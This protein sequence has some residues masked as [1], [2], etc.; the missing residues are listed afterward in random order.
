MNLSFVISTNLS[1]SQKLVVPTLEEKKKTKEKIF[2]SESVSN[3]FVKASV[4]K[5]K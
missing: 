3:G 5:V 2:S 1:L 4:D